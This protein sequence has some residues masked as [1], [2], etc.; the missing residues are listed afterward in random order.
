[1]QTFKLQ[2]CGVTIGVDRFNSIALFF[3]FTA[4]G[5]YKFHLRRTIEWD[6]L[7]HRKD[8]KPGAHRKMEKDYA[9]CWKRLFDVGIV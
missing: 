9:H 3:F 4:Y 2:D 7:R 6:S 5:K 8:S 1:M